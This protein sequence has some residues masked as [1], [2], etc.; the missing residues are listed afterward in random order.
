MAPQSHMKWH[1]LRQRHCHPHGTAS[2]SEVEGFPLSGL[3]APKYYCDTSIRI[4]T[5]T[6]TTVTTTMIIVARG[7]V[8]P[9]S[10]KK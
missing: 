5:I 1:S 3:R 9:S 6:A 10:P 2:A 8:D 4:P 7:I